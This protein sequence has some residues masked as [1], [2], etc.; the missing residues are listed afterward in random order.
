MTMWEEEDE[1]TEFWTGSDEAEERET[2]RAV[3]EGG[4]DDWRARQE[5]RSRCTRLGIQWRTAWSNPAVQRRWAE[6]QATLTRAPSVRTKTPQ[7]ETNVIDLT[8]YN[9]PTPAG[10]MHQHLTKT[11]EGFADLPYDEQWKSVFAKNRANQLEIIRA[12]PGRATLGRVDNPGQGRPVASIAI[13]L[14]SFV[15][16]TKIE[17]LMGFV[18]AQPGGSKLDYDATF[19][20]ACELAKTHRI[21][22]A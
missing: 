21:T 7:K 2:A 6:Y 19:V 12:N 3:R 17:K 16:R 1:P 9:A 14:S 10:R 4:L 13:D 18:R 11:E 8:N 15:G 20:R 5:L 22:G